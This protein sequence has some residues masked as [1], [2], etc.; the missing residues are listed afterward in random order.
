MF[1]SLIK[2]KVEAW[3]QASCCPVRNLLDYMRSAGKLRPVQI[4]AIETYLYLKIAC[5]NRPLYELFASGALNTLD[6]NSL[7][8]SQSVRDFL[9]SHPDSLALLQFAS[10]LGANGKDVLA[11]ALLE[12]L[13][14]SPQ[15][16]E[17][18]EVFRELFYGVSYTDYLFSLPMG[19]GKTFLMAAFIYLD[20]AFAL[21]EPDNPAFARNFLI[22]APS[23]LKSSIVPS[24]RT[25]QMFD[26]AWVVADPLATQLRRRLQFLVLDAD[27]TEAHSNRVRNPNVQ[28][29]ASLQP[30][31]ELVGLVAVTNAEK[32]ILDRLEDENQTDMF[33]RTED[34]KAAA[35][36]E[37]RATI[38]K[39]PALSIFIDEA[40]HAAASEIKLRGVVSKWAASGSVCTVLGFSGTPFLATAEKVHAGEGLEI[41]TS[42]IAN[43]VHYFPLVDGIGSFLK[44]PTVQIVHDA[45]DTLEIVE[46]GIKEFLSRFQD[47]R[48]ASGACAKLAVYCGSIARLEEQINPLAVR[49][50]EANGLDPTSAI[51]RYHRGNKEYPMPQGAELAFAALDTPH[52]TVRIVLLVQIGKE[53]WDCRSLAGVVL[54]QEGDCP[55]NMVLQTSCRCLR[56]VAR[57]V[58]EEAIIVLNESNGKALATQLKRQQHATLDEFQRGA[59][60]PIRIERFDRTGILHLPDLPFFQLSVSYGAEVTEN[61]LSPAIRLQELLGELPRMRSHA[62][63]TSGSFEDLRSGIISENVGNHYGLVRGDIPSC[64]FRTWLDLLHKES[65]GF[66]TPRELTMEEETLLREIHGE[67]SFS[68]S[69]GS[70]FLSPEYDQ[71][72]IRTR[73]ITA[74]W[75]RRH[76]SIREETIEQKAR[77]LV[78]ASLLSPIEVS[79][80]SLPAFVP[81]QTE[82]RKI[83]EADSAG[84][85]PDTALAEAE[86]KLAEA[87]AEGDP[88]IIDI[89][90]RKLAAA[91]TG[92]AAKDRSYHYLP[93]RTDS[94][95]ER[96]FL[97]EALRR[98]ELVQRGLEVYY[99]GDSSLTEFRIHCYRRLPASQGG[100]WTSVGIYTPDFLVLHRDKGSS[101]IDACLIVETKG[102]LYA[103]EPSFQERK[104]FASGEFLRRNA[105]RPGFPRFDYLYI[106][107]N[108]DWKNQFIE[109]IQRFFG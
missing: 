61:P 28:K 69:S 91:R 58:P 15:T 71:S 68:D 10:Q 51:L 75:P 5:D 47:K 17:A 62:T 109:A 31:S 30:F 50:C 102:R 106:E 93:Y 85:Q 94:G 92:Q 82:C 73:A 21:Q 38:A 7:R 97:D 41:K 29:L 54:S 22:L 39:I 56:E 64:P 46:R 37:L 43:T 98:T 60:K 66:W 55:V 19:A 35:A 101:A 59:E 87:E 70:V 77:L 88:D 52:S 65:F 40:H 1:Y 103:N 57:S 80:S 14:E 107:E 67:I 48:Y 45:P 27:S 105:P 100:G 9:A 2:K 90:R 104:V 11:P 63:V 33:G 83:I 74:F 95:F 23:G 72:A 44:K 49:L 25:I 20:L 13:E 26:P 99:N 8:V 108:S 89:R 3:T 16:I 76:L 53:G 81:N 4:E 24:L 79:E 78:I 34:E 36:N 86:R 18:T 6:P 84:T 32:V 96:T 42:E 12:R